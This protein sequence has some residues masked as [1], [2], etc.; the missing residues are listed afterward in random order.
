MKGRSR[1]W[2][3]GA[4]CLLGQTGVLAGEVSLELEIPRLAV[5][6]YHRP[7]VAVWLETDQGRHLADLA[8]WYD[9]G[10][11]NHEGASWLKDLR[12]WWRRSGRQLS[13]PA[14]GFTG[15]TRAPG[16]HPVPLEDARRIFA[17]LEP[18][19]YQVMVE[20]AR[21]VGGRELIA[22]PFEWPVE[23]QLEV[24]RQG[25]HELGEVRLRLAP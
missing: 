8:V 10:Q 24:T 3:A 1:L 17:E 16:S 14:D 19:Q 18:G 23:E 12:M 22:V 15:A 6:E 20:A 5:A 2:L 4:C 21:E 11:R 9:Q 25:E 7:Y 13:F